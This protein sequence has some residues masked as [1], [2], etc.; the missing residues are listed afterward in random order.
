MPAPAFV[1]RSR[2]PHHEL[3]HMMRLRFVKSLPTRVRRMLF[4]ANISP[5]DAF[6][7]RAS[8]VGSPFSLDYSC[9]QAFL[10]QCQLQE[11][12]RKAN[13]SP[14]YRHNN[15]PV[16]SRGL[17]LLFLIGSDLCRE[18]VFLAR[19]VKDFGVGKFAF[20]QSALRA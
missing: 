10:G 15:P 20:L 5:P 11:L 17:E 14:G 13:S 1:R 12:V 18:A 19:S 7:S 2:K 4:F 8:D 9:R 6:S 3:S 16:I